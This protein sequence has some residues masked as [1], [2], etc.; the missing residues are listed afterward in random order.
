GAAR[1]RRSG[2]QGTTGVSTDAGRAASGVG[3]A[4]PVESP[5]VES[6]EP[7]EPV[8]SPAVESPVAEAP[9]VESPAVE[10]PAVESPVTEAAALEEIQISPVTTDAEAAAEIAD[11][12]PSTVTQVE[13]STTNE[14]TES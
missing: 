8:E 11:E 14:S 5:A 13:G 12:A 2:S 1:P 4:P 3:E 9:V 7:V 6:V 10:S